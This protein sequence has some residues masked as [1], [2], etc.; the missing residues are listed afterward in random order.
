MQ[1]FNFWFLTLEQSYQPGI[2]F[3]C[4]RECIFINVFSQHGWDRKTT[5]DHLFKVSKKCK[6]KF[7]CLIYEMLFIKDIKPSLNTQ[8]DYSLQTVYLKSKNLVFGNIPTGWLHCSYCF[9]VPLYYDV[10]IF[11][12][13]FHSL[14]WKR[15][16]VA[17]KRRFI[18]F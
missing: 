2:H 15:R 7:D 8:T 13:N 6:S 18:T 16:E 12:L 9:I 17:S 3:R 4:L 14:T 5:I 10:Y 1:Y 11:I